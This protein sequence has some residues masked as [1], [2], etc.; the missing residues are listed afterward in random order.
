[1]RIN[2]E[3][4][5]NGTGCGIGVVQTVVT[6]QYL[7][8]VPFF[9]QF[10]PY[11]WNQWGSLGNILIGGILFAISQGTSWVR[12]FEIK[13]FLTMYGMTTLVGGLMNG[14]FPA[15]QSV[16]GPVQYGT[17]G[18]YTSEYYPNFKGHFY[19]RPASRAKGFASDVTINPMA[20]RPTK[21][22]YNKILF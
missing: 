11:P 20:A 16:G 13:S 8:G 18:F 10:I 2:K 7:G 17:N 15:T 4:I 22:P 5:A 21:V 12:N 6:K 19:R 14:I 9:D 1:M 3:L